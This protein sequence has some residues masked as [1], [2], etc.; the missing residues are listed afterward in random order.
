MGF[1]TLRATNELLV[2]KQALCILN[3]T[4]PG[5]SINLDSCR[6]RRVCSM[7]ATDGAAGIGASQ[8]EVAGDKM[9]GAGLTACIPSTAM[10]CK[11][12]KCCMRMGSLDSDS[13]WDCCGCSAPAADS[14]VGMGGSRRK[15][16]VGKL[17][18]VAL[19]AC[20]PSTVMECE[21]PKCCMRMGGINSDSRQDRR[22]CIAP[23]ADGAAGMGGGRRELAVD[24]VPGAGLK[25]YMPSLQRGA[26]R[27]VPSA[28]L[29]CSS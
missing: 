12:P 1:A 5:S 25:A 19:T 17:T 22:G 29:G 10:V 6:G 4:F 15:L 11:G 14:I 2:D 26:T 8:C 21:G 18:G 3:P 24:K 28:A 9:S 23:S 20:M 13:G 16:A 7:L 27:R